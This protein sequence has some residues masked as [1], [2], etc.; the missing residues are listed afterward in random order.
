MLGANLVIVAQ[1]SAELSRGQTKFPRI[2]SQN[3]Q[4]RKSQD[5]VL[6]QL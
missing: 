3:G 4:L 5:A 1:I 6:E 2:L